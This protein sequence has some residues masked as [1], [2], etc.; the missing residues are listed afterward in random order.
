MTA[1]APQHPIVVINVCGIRS[2]AFLI[3]HNNI[4]TLSLPNLHKNDLLD[5]LS[6]LKLGWLKKQQMLDMLKWLWDVVAGL[7]LD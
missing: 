5:N 4:S 6:A 3:Q 7:I 2:D 1:A